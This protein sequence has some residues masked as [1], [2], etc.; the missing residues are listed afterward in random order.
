MYSVK[1]V[2][3]VNFKALA[4]VNKILYRCGKDMAQKYNLH[5]WD[6]SYLK[7]LIVI[8]LCVLKNEIYLVSDEHGAVATYQIRNYEDAVLFQ[9]LATDP[10]RSGK[11]VGSFCMDMI[12]KTARDRNKCRVCCEVY[13]KSQHAVDFY[14]HKG[15]REYGK[16][17]TL[18]YTE[19]Q[20]EKMLDEVGL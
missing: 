11:G 3:F 16:A 15:Y 5:H 6:D 9:K 20:M 4:Q 17:S 1:K 12:E 7:N 13:D 14:L 2:T 18:K 8:F 19:I 10:R